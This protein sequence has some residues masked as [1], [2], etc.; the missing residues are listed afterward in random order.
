VEAS[1]GAPIPPE[2]PEQ[3]GRS[4][5]TAATI[6]AGMGAV[7][8]LLFLL[9]WWLLGDAPGA[10]STDAEIVD[11]YGSE[12]SRRTLLVGLPVWLVVL[13]ALLLRTARG[14]DPELRLPAARGRPLLV[15]QPPV[16]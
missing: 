16:R 6:T 5:R 3:R 9:G 13:S 12:A 14:I 1:A 11:Y 7:H 15:R 2:T 8:A 10:D 4:L